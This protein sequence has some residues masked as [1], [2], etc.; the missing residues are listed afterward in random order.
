VVIGSALYKNKI[1]FKEA[2]KLQ[3]LINGE[4]YEYCDGDRHIRFITSW[5]WIISKKS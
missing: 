4:N 2:L 1:D 5:T 3:W